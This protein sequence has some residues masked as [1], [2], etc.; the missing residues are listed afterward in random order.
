MKASEENIDMTLFNYLE[1][2]YSEERALQIEKEIA[3][4]PLIQEELSLWK[5]SYIQ[6]EWHDTSAMEATLIQRP[7]PSFNFTLFLNSILVICLTFFS[8]TNTPLDRPVRQ[9]HQLFTADTLKA[10]APVFLITNDL[11]WPDTEIKNYA[12]LFEK[13]S[14]NEIGSFQETIQVVSSVSLPALDQICPRFTNFSIAAPQSIVERKI[15][16]STPITKKMVRE[17][18]QAYRKMINKSQKESAA[19]EFIKGNIPYVVPIDTR[20]F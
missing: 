5:S 11:D 19:R 20:N 12:P 9:N 13:S 17:T 4:D 18:S 1:G 16:E 3:S 6:S 15:T 7:I 14:M 2:N 10:K 8:S